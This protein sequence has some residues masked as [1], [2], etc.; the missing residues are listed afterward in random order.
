MKYD[1]DGRGCNFI[2][3]PQVSSRWDS[4]NH[5]STLHK[6]IYEKENYEFSLYCTPTSSSLEFLVE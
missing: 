3:E 5:V 1:D 2:K 4:T 6:S